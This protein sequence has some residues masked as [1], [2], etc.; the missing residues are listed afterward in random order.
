MDKRKNIFNNIDEYREKES[1]LDNYFDFTEFNAI[2]EISQLLIDQISDNILSKSI[3]YIIEKEDKANKFKFFNGIPLDSTIKTLDSIRRCCIYGSFSDANT[4]VR[5]YRDDLMQFMY[6]YH[7]A[8]I[9]S[10]KEDYK[11]A[12]V[13][14][15]DAL[16]KWFENEL[17]DDNA[18]RDYYDGNKYKKYFMTA[19][20]T[21]GFL[22]ECFDN[23]QVFWDDINKL[24]NSFVHSNGEKYLKSNL[25]DYR[26]KDE[27]EYYLEV[28]GECIIKITSI[29]LCFL[30]LIDASLFQSS[31][32]IDYIECGEIPIENSQYFITPVTQ[33]FIDNYL[34]ILSVNAKEYIK[35]HNSCDMI[36]D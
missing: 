17:E 31:E 33:D 12:E 27:V 25:C 21:K 22:I 26:S 4:L 20:E 3:I 13:N 10:L 34:Q 19:D 15:F 14:R 5:K 1:R 16:N 7:L 24:N 32:F 35:E 9:K 28:T 18:K 2:I 8:E 30:M 36:I 29:L 11:K 6:N 23:F